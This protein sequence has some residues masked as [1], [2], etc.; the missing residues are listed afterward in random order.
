MDKSELASLVDSGLSQ[1]QIAERTNKSQSSIKHWLKKYN[2][3][4]IK[5]I[6]FCCK[7][8]GETNPNNA[9][10]LN[11]STKKF[12]KSLCNDCQRKKNSGKWRERKQEFVDYKGSKCEICGYDKC[13][14]ALSFHHKD[15]SQKDPDWNLMKNRLLEKVKNE[16][17]KCSLLC[18][19]CHS[20]LH[21]SEGL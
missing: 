6:K 21:W 3:K 16:L 17:D 15:T 19:N 7:N 1:R 11:K 10:S 8:C 13:L 14:G 4:T 2:L 5:R 9:F 18:N 12:H 20:E